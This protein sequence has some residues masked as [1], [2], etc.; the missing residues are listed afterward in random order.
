MGILLINFLSVRGADNLQYII[1]YRILTLHL[2]R[3]INHVLPSQ[4]AGMHEGPFQSVS[5]IHE[6]LKDANKAQACPN[7]Q[8]AP[9]IADKILQ[10]HTQDPFDHLVL[11]GFVEELDH[12]HLADLIFGEVATRAGGSSVQVLGE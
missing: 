1:S 4:I 10:G 12:S 2:G 5:D 11:L 8:S 3:Y 7:A 9:D 6:G